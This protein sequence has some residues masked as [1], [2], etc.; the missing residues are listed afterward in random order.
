MSG[1]KWNWIICEIFENGR[2]MNY[3]N[4]RTTIKITFAR[5]VQSDFSTAI[6]IFWWMFGISMFDIHFLGWGNCLCLDIYMRMREWNLINLTNDMRKFKRKQFRRQDTWF[7]MVFAVLNGYRNNI[8]KI[9][10]EISQN[11]F[12][13][14]WKGL[15]TLDFNTNLIESMA[16][17]GFL[18]HRWD[19]LRENI[20]WKGY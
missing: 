15:N 8:C 18:H 9:L 10:V 4:F 6:I 2:N 17:F 1:Q 11:G 16:I 3:N 5:F 12:V 20:H 19:I 13:W 7:E 14:R